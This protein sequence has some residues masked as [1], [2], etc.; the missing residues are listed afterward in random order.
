VQRRR[1]WTLAEK[2][3]IV[4]AAIAPGA[5]AS[6]VARG[7]R[8]SRQPIVPLAA[9]ALQGYASGAC[10][11]SCGRCVRAENGIAAGLDDDADRC[12]D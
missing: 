12:G 2:E 6:E 5:V 9:A 8:D 1:R 11:F 7:G 4:A 3:R 10:A